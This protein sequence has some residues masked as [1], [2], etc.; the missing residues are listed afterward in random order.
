MFASFS[1]CHILCVVHC[2]LCVWCVGF[3]LCLLYDF[4]V[5]YKS[6]MFYVLS[7]F[8]IYCVIHVSYVLCLVFS[9]NFKRYES[10][11]IWKMEQKRSCIEPRTIKIDK[12]SWFWITIQVSILV[13]NTI[14]VIAK[15]PS[16]PSPLWG[17]LLYVNLCS[18]IN[19]WKFVKMFYFQNPK[20]WASYFVKDSKFNIWKGVCQITFQNN[21]N[22]PIQIFDV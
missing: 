10:K 2:V 7:M 19:F 20:N 4:W 9:I 1:C 15:I 11:V 22:I 16:R 13:K 18:I 6:L 12:I 3:Y 17:C 5:S 8:V 14:C 21:M